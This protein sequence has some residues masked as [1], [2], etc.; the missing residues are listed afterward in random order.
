MLKMYSHHRNI[1]TYYGA[2]IKKSPAGQDD[3]LWLVMEYCGAGSVTDLVKKTKGNC[4]KED[5]IAYICREVLRGLSHLHSHHVIH[6]DIKGQN[7]LLTENAEVKLVDFGVSAQLDRTIGRRNTFIGTPYWMAPEVIACDENADS[8]YDYRS[9]L[10]SLGITALEMAEGAPPL[11]DMHPMRA[12]FLIPRNPP[13]KLK[14][15]KWSKKF[16]TF[17]E[18]CLVKNYIHRPSTETLLRHSFVKDLPNERQVRIM[19]KD[20]LDRTK[21]KKGEKEETEYEYSGSEE[22]EDE[23]NDEEGEPSSIVNVPGE[24]TLRREFLRLQQENKNRSEAQ[25]QQQVLQQQLKDQE[26]YK[27]Q[28]LAER[29][30]RIEHQREQRKRLEDEQRRQQEGGFQWPE[31]QQML[32]RDDADVDERSSFEE[33]LRFPEAL[34][35]GEKKQ[36]QALQQQNK[37]V[38]RTL[39]KDQ[40]QLLSLQ[41]DHRQKQKD[42]HKVTRP[43]PNSTADNQRTAVKPP[44]C[45][46][47]VSSLCLKSRSSHRTHSLRCSSHYWT[48]VS[49]MRCAKQV[50]ICIKMSCTE[51]AA[52]LPV[53]SVSKGRCKL[54]LNCRN[55]PLSEAMWQNAVTSP[56]SKQI[57]NRYTLPS[58]TIVELLDGLKDY[59]K[60]SFKLESLRR[61]A[62]P[63]FTDQAGVQLQPLHPRPAE[64][65]HP[66][67]RQSQSEPRHPAQQLSVRHGHVPHDPRKGRCVFPEPRGVTPQGMC[68]RK[69]TAGGHC[70]SISN[71]SSLPLNTAH[72]SSAQTPPGFGHGLFLHSN[73]FCSILCNKCMI[74]SKLKTNQK[75]LKTRANLGVPEMKHKHISMLSDCHPLSGYAIYVLRQCLIMFNPLS[76]VPERTTSKLYFKE[77][78]N[79][80]RTQSRNIF[81]FAL[82]LPSGFQ[83]ALMDRR[84]QPASSHSTSSS[85]SST[86]SGRSLSLT[87]LFSERGHK[88]IQSTPKETQRKLMSKTRSLQLLLMW[89]CFKVC[90][91]QPKSRRGILQRGILSKD[92]ALCLCCQGIV[93][94][95]GIKSN[96]SLFKVT[97]YSSSSDEVGSSDE[98][99]R[100]PARFVRF[101]FCLVPFLCTFPPS[102]TNES[103]SAGVSVRATSDIRQYHVLFTEDTFARL[104]SISSPA[105]F[106]ISTVIPSS[107]GA[108]PFFIFSLAK[109]PSSG[110]TSGV[111]LVFMETSFPLNPSRPNLPL[112]S[113]HHGSALPVRLTLSIS[114]KRPKFH[115]YQT[116]MK[117]RAPPEGIILQPH[118]NLNQL[119]NV[120]DLK[121]SPP[122]RPLGLCNQNYLLP[123]LLQRSERQ[124][125]PGRPQGDPYGPPS[126]PSSAG[127]EG[128]CLSVL[129]VTCCVCFVLQSPISGQPGKQSSSSSSSSFTHFIDPRLLQI[130]P[131]LS[132]V[133]GGPPNF[134]CEPFRRENTRKGSVVN[135]NPTNIRPQSDTPEIRKYKKKFNAEILCAALWGVNL[136]V[137]TENGLWLLDRSGQG[138]VYSLIS[139]R[140]FQQ[141]DV[142]EGLNV[143]ITISGKKN[144]LR[145]YYLSWLRNKI[146][147]NDP[148]VEKRQ[149][150]TSVG[151]LEGCVHY[152]VVKYERIK[153]LVIALKNSVEVYA[154][155]PK[156]Y[157]KFMAFK[158]FVSLPHKP[159]SVDLTVEDGQRLKVIYGSVSG[160]HAIDVDS[161]IPYDLYLPTHIQGSIR[162]HAII[163]LPGASG[164][165][166]LACYEDE[167]VY[168]DTYGRITKETVLQWGEMPA[169]VAYLQSNQVMGWGDKAIE[170]RSVET[171]NLEGVFMHKKAQKLKFLCERND[172]VKC[173]VC[174]LPTDISCTVSTLSSG[175]IYALGCI[176]NWNSY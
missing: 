50:A 60:S 38:Q 75:N 77:L 105:S 132:P 171:G 108:F 13:P 14:S 86:Q 111:S 12:L 107:P 83:P 102:S 88:L 93:H 65:R 36:V 90:F 94:S 165:E 17:M 106:R 109:P 59:I 61:R 126:P 7:V 47:S 142:L 118:C 101:Q 4:L 16:L 21:K 95:S 128:C 82:A 9:D 113:T 100:S 143:L 31:L 66:T 133:G 136:L 68:L 48:A 112:P 34:K 56:K 103:T 110:V 91:L 139:R 62:A 84:T 127:L 141:M 41:H 35:R 58:H 137:G 92:S 96:P 125:G 53:V 156:P 81:L 6:R 144:K 27:R 15:R 19:L 39:T 172:K 87:R 174:S 69:R 98:D 154:W 2:F 175:R 49:I 116:V 122:Q 149:G 155:A 32:W 52:T 145:L 117:K 63:A 160:F 46:I 158:S 114:L 11:C 78:S 72:C 29:Q 162:P 123:D 119:Q 10:W 80:Q 42:S 176:W 120:A 3:Q 79:H 28:L 150:W 168:F 25:R 30:K 43:V 22:E 153:F 73:C 33:R 24:S 54:I 173:P 8:T 167:G 124:E 45:R 147:R 23:M 40:T 157:H 130:S 159:L 151:D 57:K 121:S 74:S 161:G 70:I 148:D 131:P 170:L 44:C 55:Q 140:R 51:P 89:A 37:K 169:S 104:F 20:H 138:K 18:S 26:K 1:A 152:K 85:T 166:L 135:V 146:L 115:C 129:T 97:D 64:G 163:I 99:E 164:R 71:N 5:W 67:E 76:K 134:K